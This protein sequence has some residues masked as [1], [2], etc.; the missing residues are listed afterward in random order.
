MSDR[1]DKIP[2]PSELEHDFNEFISKK[3]GGSV[4]IG[5]IFPMPKG[6]SLEE[7]EDDVQDKKLKI[8][9]DLLPEELEAYLNKFVIKQDQAKEI[10]ATKI[11]THFQRIKLADSVGPL[12]NIKNN[13]MLIG[14]TGVGKTYLIKL[15]AE[16]IGV[17]FVKGDATKFSETGYVGGDVE[18]LV[19]DLVHEADGNIELA[20]YGII[21]IDEIDKIAATS[22]TIG[23]DVSRTGVQR[24]LLKLMEDTDVDLKIP[25]DLA[26]QLEA[27]MRFQKTGKIE[28]KKVNTKNILFIVSG[29]FNGLSDIVSHRL[30]T[31]GIGFGAK[32][33]KKENRD[34]LHH[35]KSE[36]LIKYGFESE[37]VGRLPVIA[38]LDE[39]TVDDLY[40]ILQNPR[41][42]V[43]LGKKR[44]FKAYGI[45][46]KFE[47]EALYRIAQA[48]YKEK[49]GARG[50]VSAIERFIL[51]YEKK[52][53]S[54]DINKLVV[55]KEVVTAPEKELSNLLHNPNA[56]ALI[57]KYKHLLEEEN[58]ILRREIRKFQDKYNKSNKKNLKFSS[59]AEEMIIEH[60]HKNGKS[61]N[62]FCE[63]I[64]RHYAEIDQQEEEFF[65]NSG[66]CVKFN[67]AARDLIIKRDWQENNTV[68]DVCHQVMRNYEHGLTLIKNNTGKNEFII[69][70]DG[71]TNPDAFLDKLIKR[72]FS[73]EEHKENKP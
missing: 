18:Q 68:A 59:I 47:D 21:Y 33:S 4:R 23:P 40:Q 63:Q 19:R 30:H 46:L 35:V 38:V 58:E 20:Q 37:F 64:L 39:L 27:A 22:S 34:Y 57:H 62:T 5:S 70:K 73:K 24:N 42:P 25:H 32:I 43:I 65:H 8:K 12:G 29:A 1:K 9:F 52:L 55:T 6:E 13:I 15:I 14:P 2:T 7:E 49:T 66:L 67:Q 69:T 72:Y 54:T 31:K 50:L 41:C 44:D 26:S 36:D 48:A 3:Y 56:P 45:D 11:C 61:V 10:L 51:K 60:V 16:K 17:P 53:P 71:V 28:K